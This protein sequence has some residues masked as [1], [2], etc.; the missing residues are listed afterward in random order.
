MS[1]ERKFHTRGLEFGLSGSKLSEG[2]RP[3]TFFF[4]TWWLFDC[5]NS[6]NGNSL[7]LASPHNNMGADVLRSGMMGRM[8]VSVSYRSNCV[9]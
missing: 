5:G 4:R 8:V 3:I 7:L 1:K 6:L 9:K 2:K